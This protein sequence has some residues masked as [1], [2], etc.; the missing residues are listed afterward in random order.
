MKIITKTTSLFLIAIFSFIQASY[1][2]N[3]KNISGSY[4]QGSIAGITIYEDGTFALYGYATLVLGTYV[5]ENDEI[6]FTPDIPQHSFEVL[7]RERKEISGGNSAAFTFDGQFADDETYIAIDEGETKKI[8]AD[9]I[10]GGGA[11]HLDFAK[12]PSLITLMFVTSKI[13]KKT[14]SNTF[15]LEG[16]YNDFLLF[17][18]PVIREQSPFTGKVIQEN[19][20]E[21][22]V[23]RWGTFHKYI[24]GEEGKEMLEFIQNYKKANIANKNDTIFYFNEQLKTAN[25]H[26]HLTEMPSIFDI[27]NYILDEKSNKYIHKSVYVKGNNYLHTYTDDYHNEDIILKYIKINPTYE[28]NTDLSVTRGDIEV[29]FPNETPEKNEE[30]KYFKNAENAD[31]IEEDKYFENSENSNPIGVEVQ[32]PIQPEK[33]LPKKTKKKKKKNK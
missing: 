12:K 31:T 24:K 10:R 23:C 6:K 26:N 4:T 29:L 28:Y 8:F 1:A 20:R 11:K 3:I 7:G 33:I 17:Y 2:Q 15:N 18:H 27:N 5:I 22:L 21:V 32:E 9:D 19:K 16:K 30:V 14:N 25:G 13:Q